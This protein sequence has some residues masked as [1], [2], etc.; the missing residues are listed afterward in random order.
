VFLLVPAHPGSPGQRVVVVVYLNKNCVGLW[1]Y[2][3]AFSKVHN[4]ASSIKFT[5]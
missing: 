2:C 4:S 5:K 1:G 3:D